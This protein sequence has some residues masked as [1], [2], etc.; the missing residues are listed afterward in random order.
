MDTLIPFLATQLIGAIIA[1]LDPNLSAR[2]MR[3]L[4]GTF[5][6]K[7][8]FVDAQS[9]PVIKEL[10]KE[11]QIDTEII[12]FDGDH[13]G[14]TQF[15]ELMKSSPEENSFKPEKVKSDETALIVF[16]SGTTGFPKGM[17]ISN[18]SVLYCAMSLLYVVLFI[19]L[20]F[21]N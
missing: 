7:L 1:S 17:C 14:C 2:D 5:H 20:S 15:S 6:P 11:N 4:L 3:Y 13:E 9:L 21:M 12:I 10:F 8:T 18:Y 19:Y 16:S